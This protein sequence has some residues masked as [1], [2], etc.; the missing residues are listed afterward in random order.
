MRIVP[1]EGYDHEL[2]LRI[3]RIHGEKTYYDYCGLFLPE[4]PETN[5]PKLQVFDTCPEFTS[6]IPSIVYD[7]EKADNVEDILE[8]DGDDPYD[9]G[10]Y[11]IKEIDRFL[12][13]G[14]E[15]AKARQRL[16]GIISQ[17]QTSNDQTS[18]Y[19]KMEKLEA[20]GANMR[21]VQMYHH[22]RSGRRIR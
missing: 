22:R 18:F 13:S 10:R 12:S 17:F 9:G 6:C 3:R 8:F 14:E 11:L 7:E 20:E 21:P 1:K 19:R 16:D 4:V 2:A 15:A 5:I